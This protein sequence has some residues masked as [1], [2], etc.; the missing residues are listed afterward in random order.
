[1]LWHGLD[2]IIFILCEKEKAAGLAAILVI[3][4]LLDFENLKPI[5]LWLDGLHDINLVDFVD[6][7]YE[8]EDSRGI[9]Q[10]INVHIDILL[11]DLV[12][13][14]ILFD[15]IFNS[16]IAFVGPKSIIIVVNFRVI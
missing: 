7:S 4:L 2:N 14:V 1:M 10:D 6:C 16:K 12:I 3:L 8:P 11:L 9:R 13:D 5:Q 15:V